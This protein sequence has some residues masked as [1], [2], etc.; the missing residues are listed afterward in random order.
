MRYK[1]L[2]AACCCCAIFLACEES[3]FNGDISSPLNHE[4]RGRIALSDADNPEGIYVWMEDT[5]LST[6]TNRE[7]NFVL[8]LP[9]SATGSAVYASGV[10]NLY[11]YVANYKLISTPV[12]VVDGKF[13]YSRGEVNGN[14]EL[15]G[16]LFMEKLL[17]ITTAV[18][19]AVVTSEYSAAIN[20]LVTLRALRDSVDVVFPKLVGG[21]LGA[22]LFRNLETGGIIADGPEINSGISLIKRIGNEAETFSFSFDL[23]RGILPVGRYEIIPYFFIE[24]TRMPEGLLPSISQKSEELGPDFL[25]IPFRRHGGLFAIQQTE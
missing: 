6:T 4:I 2:F 22:I 5:P 11:F 13:L 7:G 24:Q 25:K 20:V 9:P 18:D 23:K 8:S 16:T 17:N 1:K 3:P 10:F 19:P 12:T 14:G 21:E 15:I